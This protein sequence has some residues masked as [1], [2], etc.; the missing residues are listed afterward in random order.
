[1][2]VIL[3]AV[4]MES[5]GVSK[6]LEVSRARLGGKVGLHEGNQVGEVPLVGVLHC[7]DVVCA[8]GFALRQAMDLRPLGQG[9]L[10]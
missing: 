10:A 8:N 1:M 7:V 9:M 6:P 2:K 3:C 5:L 4:R